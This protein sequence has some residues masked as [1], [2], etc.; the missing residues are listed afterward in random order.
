[1]IK[2]ITGRLSEPSSYAAIGVG[3]IAIGTIMGIGE[4]VFVGLG[5]AILGLI[6]SEE[7]KK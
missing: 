3:V 1:M 5:C 4:L 6:L 2:W 7:A